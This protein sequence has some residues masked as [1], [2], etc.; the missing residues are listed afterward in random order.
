MSLAQEYERQFG[1]RDWA[2]AFDALPAL[3]GKTVLD[4]GCGIGAQAAE[5]VARGAHVIGFDGNEELLEVARSRF[6]AHAEF[7]RYDLHALPDLGREVDGVWCSFA[8]AYFPD[9]SAVL[10]AWTR[11]LRPGGWVALTEIDDLFAHEPLGDRTRELLESY[12]RDA[13]AA[14]RY[15]FRMGRKL[16]PHL[17]RAGLAVSRVLRLADQEFSFVGA[18]LPEVLAAWRNRF[19]RMPRLRDDCGSE[20]ERLEADFLG[21]LARAEHRSLA[22]VYCSI[23]RK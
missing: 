23:A 13:L 21:C 2:A 7:E 8:A 10:G 17:E 18:A 19:E 5:L 11:H 16:A 4:L 22:K 14:G 6:L 15:D 1:W 20:F 3:R 12:V 9:L